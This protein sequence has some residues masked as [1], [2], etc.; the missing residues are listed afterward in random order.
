VVDSSGN[1]NNIAS[2]F[3]SGYLALFKNIRCPETS[4]ATL[5]AA[6]FDDIWCDS[7]THTMRVSLNGAAYFPIPQ[8]I[9]S[10]VAG[11][12]TLL[13]ANSCGDGVTATVAGA[14]PGMSVIINTP[15]TGINS[16]LV[17]DTGHTE[18][19]SSN[20]VVTGYCNITGGGITPSAAT[21]QIRVIQ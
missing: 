20:T 8:E 7:A 3:P 18:V 19:S 5:G 14:A 9:I 6:G 10:T 13:A 12:T 15:T 16:G 4:A 11:S 1:N 21:L 2:Q 17:I